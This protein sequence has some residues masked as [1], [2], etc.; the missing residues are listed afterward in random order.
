MKNLYHETALHFQDE[1]FEKLRSDADQVLQKLLANMVE[2]GSSEGRL[3]I[4]VDISLT[5]ETVQN[6]YPNIEGETRVVHTPKFQHKVGSVLQIKNE[7]KG[8]MN[9]DGMEMVW[10]DVKG[11]Y[12]L[13][14]ITG[15]YQMN[16]YDIIY[17]EKKED[18]AADEEVV[19][20]MTLEG[21]KIAALP[22][23]VVDGEYSEAEENT[24]SGGTSEENP[25][26]EEDI[27]EEFEDDYGYQE[28]EEF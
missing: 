27:S 21:R 18:D 1:T 12:V 3:T 20:G 10:D 23:P 9:C 16:I 26:D 13:Q 7:Q 8:D 6:R 14:P 11:E 4:T 24:E 17:P 2:K 25:A 15:R 19:E 5:Q 28:P 22:G